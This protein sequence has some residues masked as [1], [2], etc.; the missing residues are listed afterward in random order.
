MSTLIREIDPSNRARWENL[1]IEVATVD[2]FQGRECDVVLYSTVRSNPE[3]SIGF[4]RDYRR[5]NVA[6][7]R[8]RSLLVIVGDH[9]TMRYAATGMDEN[10]FSKVLEHIRAYPAECEI[11]AAELG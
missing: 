7:S 6:L 10:P 9:N 4:L 1:E 8:A 2:S 5:V 3:G 11:I